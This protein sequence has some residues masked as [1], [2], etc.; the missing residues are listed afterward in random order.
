MNQFSIRGYNVFRRNRNRF[1]GGLTLY[2]NENSPCKH[3]TDHLVFSDLELMVFELHQ[4]KRK[5][6]LL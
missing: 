3:L 2:V 1:G 5:W 4:S 6:L